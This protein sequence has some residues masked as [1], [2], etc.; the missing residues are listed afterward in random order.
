LQVF[1]PASLQ[2]LPEAVPPPDEEEDVAADEELPDDAFVPDDDVCEPEEVFAPEE[3]DPLFP[4]EPDP[5]DE[6]ELDPP[7]LAVPFIDPS[8]LRSPKLPPPPFEHE[9]ERRMVVP[10]MT[11]EARAD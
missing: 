10:T 11:A 9:L 4:G 5:E 6:P 7:V 2:L 8:W 1:A 3:E